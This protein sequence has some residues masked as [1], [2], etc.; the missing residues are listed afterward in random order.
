MKI[1]DRLH[2]RRL[3]GFSLK[4]A[5]AV[6]AVLAVGGNISAASITATSASLA[7]VQA[8]VNAASDGD[9]V[10]IPDGS[11]TWTGG[12]ST[13]KQIVVQAQNFTPTPGGTSSRNVT[14]THNSPS[15]LFD[16]VS[17]NSFHCGVGGIRFNE[18]TGNGNAVRF[19]GTGSKVPLLFDCYFQN[20]ERFGS[21]ESVA[22]IAWLSQG[23]V[24]WNIYIDGTGFGSGG[25]AGPSV[26]SVCIV[27]KSPRSWTTASTMGLL[28]ISGAVNVYFED[29]TFVNTGAG[30]LDDNARVVIR[31]CTLDGVVWITHGFTST[32]GGRHWESYNNTYRVS[33]ALRN[34]AGRYFWCRAGTGVFFDNVVNNASQPVNYGSVDLLNI[35]DNTAPTTY[36]MPR[37]PGCGHSG[38]SYVSDPIYI[39]N[40][41]GARAY[42][43]SIN[44]SSGAWDVNVRKDRDIYVN[45]GPKPGY[46]KFPYPHPLR[47]D[48][49]PSTDPPAIT[50]GPQSMTR[51]A[52][53]SATFSVT[54]IG[55]APL[56]FQWQRDQVSIPGATAASLTISSVLQ[57]DAGS[58]R[59]VV[60]NRYGSATSAAATLTVQT[61]PLSITTASLSSGAVA[62]PYSV[63]LAASG[64]TP[65]YAWSLAG[66]TLPS[67][68]TLNSSSGVISGTPTATGS[69]SFTVQIRDS[70]SPQQTATKALTITIASTPPPQTAIS[71]WSSTTVPVRVDAGAD[72]PVELGVKFR[73]DVAGTVVGIR[74]YKGT[75]NTGTHVGSLWTSSGTRLASVTF[76][77]ESAAGW[78]Q[79][80]F[81]TPVPI[82]AN[83]TYIA[84]YHCPN[85]HYSEDLNFFASSGVSNPPLQAL[86]SPA[87]G[88]NNVYAYGSA[89]T[90]PSQTY[91]SANYWVDVVLLP[92]SAPPGSAPALVTGPTGLTRAVGETASF[93]VTATGTAPLAYQWQKNRANL[94]GASSASYSIGSV[95]QADGGVYRCIVSNSYGSAT[96]AEATLTVS[97][98]PTATA[99]YVD[100]TAGSDGNPG[101]LSSPWRRCPGL[102]GWSGSA[103][104][105]AGDTVYFKRTGVWT[106]PQNLSGAGLD[107]KGGVQYIGDQWNP[108]AGASG[109]AILRATGRHE[110]GVVRI[111][112]DHESLPTSIEGFEI[113]ANGQRANLVDIN[114]AFWKAGLTR[115]VKRIK[116]CVA[117][118]NTGNGSEGDY[119]YGIIVSDH[120]PDA[121][122]RVANVEILNTVV[123]N[124]PRD[125]IC[126]YPGDS[127]MISNI[128]VRACEVYG[129][130]TDPSYSE[131]H[132]IAIKGDVRN[133]VIE[134]SYAHDV[135]SSAVFING[136]ESGSGP[137]PSGCIVRLNV[138][139]TADNN[140]V[141]R[142]YGS[143]SKSVDIVGNIVL[144][145]EQT[146]GL[147]FAG[148]SGSLIAR[149]FNNTFYNSFVDIGNPSSTG[150]LEF[151]N[152]IIYELDDIPLTDS[153]S[154]I[155]AHSNNLYFRSG[156]GTV[157][158]IGGTSYTGTSVTGW[159]GTA[160]TA[161]PLFQDV[162]SLPSGFA[163][164]YA[165]A[166]G[167][168]TA[169]LSLRPGSPGLGSGANLGSAYN[170]SINSRPRPGSVN[171]DRGSYQSP[172]AVSSLEGPP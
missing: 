51:T 14:I 156:G 66:G 26:A 72:S 102:V 35:G 170:G 128:V 76:S 9:T 127:G 67:G 48:T 150:T 142:F 123:Y 90:F 97:A 57:S 153:G 130:G 29:S 44:T 75:S 30:D 38:T 132:G 60:T 118:G 133:S 114:H 83:T 49:T 65:S 109:R 95:Q 46:T 74:F 107:L 138:L 111:W 116:N 103:T 168:N 32:W 93:S 78:Q 54:A 77:G 161:D 21:A 22:L 5:V 121:S 25:D 136:P 55:A 62:A 58:Y 145:N 40:N 63:T 158:R 56:S 137:G 120:S 17:G 96:S 92:E 112:E 36:L 24:A 148:N 19:R 149:V 12:I 23:G 7:A 59:C 151:R 68:L 84:S 80:N 164:W 89:G 139:Q 146:G 105:R 155:T 167:P 73:S 98:A 82:Q 53:E 165:G 144:E 61:A 1:S 122:G 69:S 135:N 31:N 94:T 117:H 18:G 8:A 79:A 160:L 13:T 129:T 140:G 86:S 87:S 10:L 124:T 100:D 39:W 99:Y 113:D 126:L 15:P 34:H 11:A 143:G 3:T 134:Y 166:L 4:Q 33:Y 108:G 2:R 110:A 154:D 147:S 101:T 81:A 64:G 42:T 45:S 43:W 163:Y 50:Q 47:T 27:F 169:G 28:D 119:K 157:A 159:E 141:I 71:V 172:V 37:Q 70:G 106:I 20:K 152:N 16:M 115:A 41:T 88:G 52:G 91:S 85:G 104:L 125:G 162:T 6:A 131:G 171:W